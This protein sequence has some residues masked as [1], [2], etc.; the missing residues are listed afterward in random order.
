MK[1][2]ALGYVAV[3][4]PEAACAYLAGHD[5]G[6]EA[7]AVLVPA[8]LGGRM[9]YEPDLRDFNFARPGCREEA[10][11]SQSLWRCS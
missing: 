2:H 10:R 6:A 8:G 3:E 9:F 11:H 4:S 5:S 7:D 1:V